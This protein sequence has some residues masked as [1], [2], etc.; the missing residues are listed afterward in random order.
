LASSGDRDIQDVIERADRALYQ[1]KSL[2]RNRVVVSDLAP[3][4]ETLAA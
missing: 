2:G 4:T 3:L 1:A